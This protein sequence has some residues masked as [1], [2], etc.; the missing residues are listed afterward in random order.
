[1]STRRVS[2]Y[3]LT[4]DKGSNDQIDWGSVAKDF[5]SN[6]QGAIDKRQLRK[7]A[8][9]DEYKTSIDKLSD[10]PQSDN[11]T[12]QG[13]LVEAAQ[14]SM[15]DLSNRYDLVKKGIMSVEDFSLF[16]TNQ[17]A[18]F[19]TTS[20]MMQ[21]MGKWATQTK[22]KIDSGKA[23]STEIEIYDKLTKYGGLEG[24][25]IV[26]GKNGR[27][28]YAKR[29]NITTIEE[30]NIALANERSAG[31]NI[32]DPSAIDKKDAEEW[33]KNNPKYAD[34]DD[35]SGDRISVSALSQLF[36]YQGETG[37]EIDTTKAI[38][39]QVNLLGEYVRSYFNIETGVT[40][41]ISDIKRAPGSTDK[42]EGGAIRE[43][44]Q[45]LKDKLATSNAEIVQVL[46]TIGGYQIAENLEDAKERYGEDV[47]VN[48][49]I[50]VNY[51]NGKVSYSNMSGLKAKADLAIDQAINSQIDSS[52]E[53]TAP[54]T[55]YLNYKKIDGKKAN[56]LSEYSTAME[57]LFTT[58]D[59]TEF[60]T[61]SRLLV[62]RVNDYNTSIGGTNTVVGIERKGNQ[63]IINFQDENGNSF[64]SNPINYK[65]GDSTKA[66]HEAMFS[67]ITPGDQDFET[68]YGSLG[69]NTGGVSVGN[70][71]NFDLP[72]VK[73]EIYDRNS[74]II[75]IDDEM[76]TVSQFL[77]NEGGKNFNY[78]QGET[79]EVAPAVKTALKAL[80]KGTGKDS[81]ISV[82]Y[83]GETL[84]INLGSAGGGISRK[85]DV[86]GLAGGGNTKKIEDVIF[87]IYDEAIRNSST[88][89][90]E[91]KVD[92]YGVKTNNDI[93]EENN[94]NNNDSTEVIEPNEN[95]GS[96]GTPGSG[97]TN[98]LTPQQEAIEST[99]LLDVI[100]NLSEIEKERLSNLQPIL[101]VN[102]AKNSYEF[103]IP[104]YTRGEYPNRNLISKAIKNVKGV[105][106][107][108]WTT[109]SKKETFAEISLMYK[110]ALKDDKIYKEELKRRKKK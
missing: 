85:V 24:V 105:P 77:R 92:I 79:K 33:V 22:A 110:L 83:D 14:G 57:K 60:E 88:K 16:Q 47:D 61:Q 38:N 21:G 106:L 103:F 108:D 54:N 39:D 100:E 41:K 87:D 73:P 52:V 11:L 5:S 31:D 44:A 78:S 18:D 65:S 75:Y 102:L 95:T 43:T 26:V 20:T 55:A 46:T 9:A 42:T 37:V 71:L 96:G 99:A 53:T 68:Y 70:P 63:Y 23:T 6:I 30:A 94:T 91:T 50:Y 101:N 62:R 56:R 76:K 25:K 86:E 97:G 4:P 15:K 81:E 104:G 67:I 40:T 45:I 84:T 98:P 35:F 49:L 13:M 8:V 12:V 59:G 29:K 80:L 72:R 109:E 1:M 3:N 66:L 48:K 34:V 64:K 32:V 17:K 36:K 2:D 74:G 19:K 93:I 58:A 28:E 51:K 90:N 107:K 69:D 7:K 10:I 82:E 89:S 27:I